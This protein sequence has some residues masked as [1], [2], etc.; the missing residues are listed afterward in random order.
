MTYSTGLQLSRSEARSV[1]SQL[2]G[3]GELPVLLFPI[4]NF[5]TFPG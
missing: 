2:S 1:T 5:V 4:L 3:L